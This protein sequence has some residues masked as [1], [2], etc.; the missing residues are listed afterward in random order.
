MQ[1]GDT[2][3]IKDSGEI[4][5]IRSITNSVKGTMFFNRPIALIRVKTDG[6]FVSRANFEEELSFR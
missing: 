6:G 4:G 5:T 2:V 3:V 1:A